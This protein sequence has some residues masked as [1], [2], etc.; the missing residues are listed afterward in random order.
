MKWHEGNIVSAIQDA[1]KANA[2]FVVVV[3]GE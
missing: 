3:H 2:L 1:K